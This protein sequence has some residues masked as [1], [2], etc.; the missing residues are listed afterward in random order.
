MQTADV[1]S[2]RSKSH[3]HVPHSQVELDSSCSGLS[4][5]LADMLRYIRAKLNRL[6]RLY[7]AQ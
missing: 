7:V 2:K 6:E 3:P 5:S 4:G 1:E